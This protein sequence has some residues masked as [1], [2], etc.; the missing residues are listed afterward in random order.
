MIPN[1]ANFFIHFVIVRGLRD[2][3]NPIFWVPESSVAI[4]L[5]KF[6]LF[7]LKTQNILYSIS[8]PKFSGKP[9]HPPLFQCLVHVRLS[10]DE[11]TF[12]WGASVFW[13]VYK[14]LVKS[15]CIDLM[16]DHTKY[17][18]KLY[19][20]WQYPWGSR[21]FCLVSSSPIP[22]LLPSLPPR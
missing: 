21:F 6:W 19:L 4:S 12:V 3:L 15:M 2:Y 9:E 7:I 11:E 5:R 1:R 13:Q 10:T 16:N 14:L 17:M 20:E 18:H 8:R 22:L